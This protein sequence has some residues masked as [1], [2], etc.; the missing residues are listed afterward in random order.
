MGV[1]EE[2]P[3]LVATRIANAAKSWATTGNMP[4]KVGVLVSLVGLGLLLR[5]ANQRGVITVTAEMILIAVAVFGGVLLGVGW[6]FRHRRPI[7]GLSLQGGGIATLYLTTFVAFAGYD[8]LAASLALAFIVAITVGAGILAVSQDSR[9]L[10]VL[11]I[12]GGFLA[13]VLSYSE[14]GDHV[15]VFTYYAIL[16]AA[17]LAV[18]SFKT[19]PEL[20]LLGFGFTFGITSFWMLH[21]HAEDDWVATQPFVALFV[22]MYMA[23]PALFALRLPFKITSTSDALW[24]SPLVFATP[25]IG[26]GLQQALVG[27][28]EYGSEMSATGLALL[29]GALALLTRRQERE[30]QDLQISYTCLAVIFIAIAVPL[31]FDAYYTSTVWSLQGTVLLWLGCRKVQKLAIGAGFL[32]QLL[33]GIFLYIHLEEFFP[34][35]Q[36]MAWL[37]NEYFLG[38][39]LIAATGLVSAWLLQR[40]RGDDRLIGPASIGALLWGGS[41]WLVAGL[42]EID[43]HLATTQLST[44]T[45]FVVLSFGLAAAIAHKVK[46]QELSV[47]GILLLPT[48]AVA[49]VVSLRIQSHALD[50]FGWAVWPAAFAIHFGLLR[51]YRRQR[52]E[53]ETVLHAGGY[54]VLLTL[55]SAETYWQVDQVAGGTWPLVAALMAAVV[56]VGGTLRGQRPLKWPLESNRR[57]YVLGG[58]G[59][60]VAGLSIAAL[61]AIFVSDG[62]PEPIKYVPLLNPLE[63]A[64]LLVLAVVLLWRS[65]AASEDDHEVKD[66]VDASWAPT[67][68]V[69]TTVFVTMTLVRTV[70]HWGDVPFDAQSMYDS[71]ALQ[72][73]I[74]IAWT[75]IALSAMVAGVRRVQ[76]SVWV[77][78]ASFMGVVVVKLFLVDLRNQETVGRVVSFI[79]VGLLLLIVGYFAPVPPSEMAANRQD[80]SD[81]ASN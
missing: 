16:N 65:A 2:P 5:E 20:N 35:P 25:F 69:L 32:L 78:G 42:L 70:H 14:P 45:A 13:P 72:A 26:L 21:R 17:V 24:Q 59:P 47:S 54:W 39:A 63:L 44:S 62:D 66:I 1:A 11:G 55:V 80:S 29:S 31:A 46:W 68:A 51:L 50:H 7:Y 56:L 67:L 37:A 49:L 79:A 10:A 71:T 40:A 57:A 75:L 52:P 30:H 38:T 81:S 64:A 6:R 34:Y 27:H 41:W 18:S 23:M 43:H 76:R 12:I 22:L 15:V 58:A 9:S 3:T 73:S 19:W 28:T 33:A 36:D 53:I 48:L 60:V 74:S 77:A 61:V 4:V 8:V